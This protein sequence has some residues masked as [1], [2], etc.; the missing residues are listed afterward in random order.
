MIDSEVIHRQP[1][2]EDK[3]IIQRVDVKPSD[4][5]NDNRTVPGIRKLTVEVKDSSVGEHGL[6]EPI[7]PTPCS[8]VTTNKPSR[9][10]SEPTFSFVTSATGIKVL[11]WFISVIFWMV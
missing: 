1:P 3:D 8:G 2:Q 4:R 7:P 11:L 6:T 10:T 5:S 9:P